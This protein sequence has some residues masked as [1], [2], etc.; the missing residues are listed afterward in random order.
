M[1]HVSEYD[2]LTIP[3]A[4]QEL[5]AITASLTTQYE[6]LGRDLAEYHKEYLAD[7]AQSAAGSVSGKNREAQFINR[8]AADL[9]INLRANINSL[10]LARDLL[11]FLLLSHEPGAVPF[12]AVARLDDE[13]LPTV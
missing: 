4:R 6:L 12:P 10:V 1:R 7:Y 5:V 8:E 13:D 3:E 11:V 9:I 2:K